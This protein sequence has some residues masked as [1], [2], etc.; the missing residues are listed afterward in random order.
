MDKKNEKIEKIE[1]VTTQK[2]EKIATSVTQNA[3]ESGE[4]VQEAVVAM[5]EIATK[6]SIIEEIARQT[7]L[8]ALN[9]NIEA[10]VD[11]GACAGD[12]VADGDADDAGDIGAGTGDPEDC[13]HDEE[14]QGGQGARN[15]GRGG[16]DG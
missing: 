14:P 1:D 12:G 4:A 3:E 15:G 2:T 13:P 10:A 16:R 9:A 5:K 7:N 8:L 11:Y 6:I